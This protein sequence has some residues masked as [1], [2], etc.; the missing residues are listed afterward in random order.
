MADEPD[1]EVLL[2]DEER[3]APPPEFVE[4][5][6][7]SDPADLRRGRARLRGLVGALGE[8]ARLVRAVADRARVGR[9]LGEVV[10][11][12]EAE[13]VAQLPR[14]PRRRGPRRQ[15]R[16]PLDRRGRRH[17]RRHLRRA[18]RHDEAVRERHEVARRR[19][20][21]RGRDLHADDPGDAGGDARLRA[22]RRHAQ[23]RL[24][25]LLGR[26]RQGAHGGLRRE[27]ARHRQR[28]PAPRQADPDEGAGRRRARRPAED[29]ARRRREARGHRHADEG[30]P[31]RL[32]ARG[33]REG[34]TP[35]ARPSRST[36]STRSTSS[37][38]PA[39][40]RSRRASC[41]RP[42]AT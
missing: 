41:T 16:L 30:R 40:P 15:G 31:R 9:A 5:A 2:K 38:R 10:P 17:A 12:G 33:G 27:A 4:Q 24:R 37:T 26:G 7:F 20:G 13:R 1:L 22:H 18:A 25:R 14:P 29:G 42:A 3:F 39:R 28:E 11:G 34:R 21:R 19:E 23:R 36:P 8:G 32:V 6:N 35:T